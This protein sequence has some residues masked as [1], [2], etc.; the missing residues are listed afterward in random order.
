M[1]PAPHGPA[2]VNRPL[3]TAIITSYH[4]P[5]I[6]VFRQNSKAGSEDR[7]C[8]R[9]DFFKAVLSFKLDTAFY[10]S[11]GP[12]GRGAFPPLAGLL[13]IYVGGK[14]M[15]KMVLLML[16]LSLALSL[17]ACGSSSDPSGG[18]TSS[19][20]QET[21]AQT[22]QTPDGEEA[23]DGNKTLTFE[24]IT[25]VDNDECLIQITG[26]DPDN[27]W[28]YTLKAS[29]ENKSAEKTYMFSVA[30]A[31]INGVECDPFF[32]TEVAPGKKSNN[33]I[34]FSTST[35]KENG[36]SDFTDIE[37]SFRVYD[38]DDWLAGNVA[39]ET[40]HV[41]PYGEE[42][43]EVFVRQPR[44]GDNIIV[45]NDY[46]SVIVTG[47]EEDAIW[48]YTVNLFLLN[49][50]EQNIMVSVD[51]ASVNG[52]MADP[53]Y[54]NSVSA[55]KCAFS[56]MSWSDTTLEDNGITAVEEIEFT[57]RVHDNDNWMADDFVNEVI[58]LHP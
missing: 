44:S 33:D 7:F 9:V 36:L 45:D 47:Y 38:S 25:A 41:Y 6:S 58:I 54:A 46:V 15:K 28:G 23:S 52:Y 37:L 14:I 12:P 16:C 39:E 10:V 56:S 20:Q 31:S 43:A 50:S 4:G 42:N 18:G 3:N 24:E 53:F 32:A 13:E 51:D 27:M 1:F 55:G 5:I 29:L 49:K 19:P 17:T 57:L 40:V 21:P 8:V 22:G 2:R 30:T 48:G 34:S 35:L 11:D 26:I